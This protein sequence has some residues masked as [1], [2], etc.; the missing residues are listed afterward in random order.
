LSGAAFAG[1]SVK[2][3][4][5]DFK[6]V[7]ANGAVGGASAKLQ[8]AKFSDGF[9][10]SGLSSSARYLYNKVVTYDADWSRGKGIDPRG[11]NDPP[12]QGYIS[13]GT[14][15]EKLEGKLFADFWKEGGYVSNTLNMI[16]GV[17]AVSKLHDRI[18]IQYKPG[19]L[20]REYFVN[21]PTMLPAAVLTYV[22]LMDKT[23]ALVTTLKVNKSLN[24][25]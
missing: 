20:M 7:L 11:F 23:P 21:A 19:T 25:R 18:V 24:M 8:G 6:K 10:Y 15:G 2:Y 1:V 5:T 3:P 9:T 22:G 17:N 16:P 4:V 14:Q 13:I 12:R